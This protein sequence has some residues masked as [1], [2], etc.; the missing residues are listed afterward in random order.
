MTL[1]C[2]R[3]YVSSNTETISH[4]KNNFKL[5]SSYVYFS[6][7]LITVRYSITFLDMDLE[8]YRNKV[9]ITG[10]RYIHFGIDIGN[11]C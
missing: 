8:L 7:I 4:H 2:F 1:N 5:F 6:W 10:F 9:M 3:A 11:K